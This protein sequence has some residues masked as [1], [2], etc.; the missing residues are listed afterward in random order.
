MPVMGC[1]GYLFFK[2]IVLKLDNALLTFAKI[3]GSFFS[4]DFIR[5][6]GAGKQYLSYITTIFSHLYPMRQPRV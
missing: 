1:L 3:F 5:Q 2:F 6:D 4:R